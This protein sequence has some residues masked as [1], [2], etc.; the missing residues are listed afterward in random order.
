[1][2]RLILGM[3]I[4]CCLTVVSGAA[5]C[6]DNGT[7]TVNGMVW[8]KDAGCLGKMNWESAMSRPKSL[9]HGQCGLTDNSKIGDWRLPYIDELKAIYSAKSLFNAVQASVYWSSSTYAGYTN[10][11]WVVFMNGGYVSYGNKGFNGYVWPVR[12]V[13]R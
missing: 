2:K 7:V 8:L 4:V 11:A 1:M 12:D 3:T 10:D 6:G 5:W 9:A 13:Q